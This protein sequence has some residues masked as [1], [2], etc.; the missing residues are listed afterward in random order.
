MST[1]TVVIKL[2]TQTFTI[3]S[4]DVY[5]PADTVYVLEGLRI[6][7]ANTSGDPIPAGLDPTTGSLR[8]LT[9]DVANLG[10]NAD[11]GTTAWITIVGSGGKLVASVA[12]RIADC[13]ANPLRRADGQWIAYDIVVVDY[14]AD[15]SEIPLTLT[16]P[17]EDGTTRLTAIAAAIGAAGGPPLT[18]PTATPSITNYAALAGTPTPAKD[19]LNDHLRQFSSDLSP[20][21]SNP[22]NG[23]RNVLIPFT[24]AG[25]LTS[26][27]ATA[28]T[29]GRYATT[30]PPGEFELVAHLLKVTFGHAPP[31]ALLGF[32][33][34]LTVDVSKVHEDITYRQSKNGD[35]N[36]V[37]VTGP[38]FTVTYTNR[39]AG[40]A[41]ITLS[42]SATVTDSDDVTGMAA[43][44]LPDVT[45]NRWRVESFQWE[46]SDA[47]IAALPWSLTPDSETSDS[48]CLR[49]QVAIPGIDN[50]INPAS[51]SGFY[52]GTLDA[53]AVTIA[54]RKIR[55]EMAINNRLPMPVHESSLGV[56][57]DEL[58]AQVGTGVKWRTGTDH[59]DPALSWYETRLARK[60]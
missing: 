25:V 19:V 51:D 41:P 6:G 26:I 24:I 8:L 22:S 59:V 17:A 45:S 60:A 38:T 42:L 3:N 12:G 4:T 37:T 58:Q 52:A 54:G 14:T 44:Y 39:S 16:R 50:A 5:D 30:W 20:G 29:S 34:G 56:T 7:W 33:L 15:L 11:L 48:S 31:G 9:R 57:W 23:G 13:S 18:L 43:M 53:A 49:A 32:K 40:Q 55:V 27:N 1:Y 28:V 35:P 10:S 21:G 36:T 47:E 46:P 2:G